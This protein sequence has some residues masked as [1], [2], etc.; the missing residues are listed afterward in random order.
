MSSKVM[1]GTPGGQRPKF[2]HLDQ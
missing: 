2:I 1:R